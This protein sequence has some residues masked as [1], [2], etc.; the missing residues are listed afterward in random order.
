[1]Q[2]V[3][4][5]SAAVV[6]LV[7]G[8]WA[9]SGRDA[10]PPAVAVPTAIAPVAAVVADPAAV[11]PARTQLPLPTP[12][13]TSAAAM[14]GREA[15]AAA[16]SIVV[17]ATD[18]TTG[19]PA[20]H[21]GL[22]ASQPPRTAPST[23]PLLHDGEHPGGR[24]LV[25]E[26]E[27]ARGPYLLED[28]RVPCVYQPS[29][30]FTREDAVMRD[31][32]RTID[33]SLPRPVLVDLVIVRRRGGAPIAD[34]KVE[35]LRPWSACPDVT[36][37]TDAQ[38][39]ASFWVDP[40]ETAAMLQR[41]GGKALRLGAATTD[42]E[43]RARLVVPP[44]EDLALR[45]LGPGLRPQVLQP[46]RVAAS[47]APQ[48]IVVEVASGGAI[49]GRVLPASTLARL[50]VDT[51]GAGT[52]PAEAIATGLRL[53][54]E[55]TGEW[56]P[57][58]WD[59]TLAL[60][61]DGTFAVDGLQPG[62]WRLFLRYP[63]RLR[64]PLVSPQGSR[65][66][67]SCPPVI[68][69]DVELPQLRDLQDGELRVFDIDIGGWL[70]GRLEATVASD[71]HILEDGFLVIA[72]LD[73]TTTP[74]VTL[75]ASPNLRLDATGRAAVYLPPARYLAIWRPIDGS[76][77]VPLQEF[78]IDSE[79]TAR[80]DFAVSTFAAAV[81][82]VESDGRTPA[83]GLVQIRLAHCRD[84]WSAG[85]TADAGGCCAFPRLPADV[86]LVVTFHRPLSMAQQQEAAARGRPDE[87]GPPIALGALPAANPQG[88]ILLQLPS[89]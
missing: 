81:R 64:D 18:A 27:L 10:A 9:M 23:Q 19:A 20:L 5:G 15:E 33:V 72:A 49:Q 37:R 78:A 11:P 69:I 7:G 1:M 66:P 73:A 80:V 60:H 4:I 86:P 57:V 39:P 42:A 53:R 59:S 87:F 43:G 38:P 84:E 28:S 14:A 65:R 45:F 75:P 25:P 47:A 79:S 82:V 85:A 89:R 61:A 67:D 32:W 17:L 71:G 29:R 41:D 16:D 54:H 58:L 46:W 22:R 21:F 24:L 51:G 3:M 88:T 36:L 8:W 31:G 12:A 56:L 6:V 83:A 2:K 77:E 30:W 74:A 55:F 50:W 26:S 35:L 70:P 34:C 52:P 40:R 13:S 62:D 44:D 76:L 63:L 48:R 68:P